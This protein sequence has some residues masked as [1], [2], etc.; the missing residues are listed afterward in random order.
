[1]YFSDMRLWPCMVRCSHSC[2]SG[3]QKGFREGK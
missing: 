3:W 2:R 1:M